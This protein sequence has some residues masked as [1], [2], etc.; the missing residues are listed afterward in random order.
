[1]AKKGAGVCALK[2]GLDVLATPTVTRMD[3]HGHKCLSELNNNQLQAVTELT[4][5][6][7]QL[8]TYSV[9][10]LVSHLCFNYVLLIWHFILVLHNCAF[11]VILY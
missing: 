7:M 11:A 1:M 4:V 10:L 2:A 9:S 3:F 8:K 5:F 6:K